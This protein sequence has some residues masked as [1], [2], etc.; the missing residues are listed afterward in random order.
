MGMP[1]RVGNTFARVVQQVRWLGKS[2]HAQRKEYNQERFL[3][4]SLAFV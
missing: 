2:C 4:G 1:D 3:H